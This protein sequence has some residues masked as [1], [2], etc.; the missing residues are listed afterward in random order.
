MSSCGTWLPPPPPAAAC[1]PHTRPSNPAEQKGE[2]P[3]PGR[4]LP[5]YEPTPRDILSG[6]L[7]GST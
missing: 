6:V 1:S 7:S 3:P 2:R 5:L 4:A